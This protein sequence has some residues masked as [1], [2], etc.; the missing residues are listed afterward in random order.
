MEQVIVDLRERTQ[1]GIE[2]YGRPLET[3]NG[4]SAK[5]DRYQELLDAAQYAKQDLLEEADLLRALQPVA[6]LLFSVVQTR[7]LET[8][9]PV[10]G[11][12][13][14]FR[15]NH[16]DLTIGQARAFVSAVIELEGKVL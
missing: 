13:I 16:T 6:R 12:R 7:D 3:H 9:E 10:P 8:G 2:T 1:R 14:L 5:L 15:S 11:D 4:R